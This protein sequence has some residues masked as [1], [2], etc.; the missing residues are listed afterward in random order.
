M[1]CSVWHLKSCAS[2]PALRRVDFLLSQVNVSKI[3]RERAAARE[4]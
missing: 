4:R 3:Y 2:F 1:R